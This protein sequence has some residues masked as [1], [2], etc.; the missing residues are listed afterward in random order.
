[1]HRFALVLSLCL[2]AC[3]SPEPGTTGFGLTLSTTTAASTGPQSGTTAGTDDPTGGLTSSGGT[4]TS[5]SGSTDAP[6][7]EGSSGG[8][9][10]SG[11]GS[12]DAGSSGGG[13]SGG[14]PPACGDAVV[15]PGEACDDGNVMGGDGCSPT[16]TV[17]ACGNGVVDQGEACDDGNMVST[18]ACLGTCALA[19]CGD[20]FIQTGVEECEG[21]AIV[22]G[23][24]ANCLVTCNAGFDDCNNMIGDGCEVSVSGDKNNCG[25][26]GKVCAGNE[27]CSAGVCKVQMGNEFGPEHSFVGFVSNHYI[28][29]GCCSVGCADNDAVQA[30]YFCQHFYGNN[31]TPKP[32]YFKAQ[33]PNPTYPKMHKNGGC[34]SNGSDIPNT[35]CDNGPCKVGNWNETTTGLTNLVCVC[36]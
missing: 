30:A 12:T 19:K 13:S 27:I 3:S 34:T 22:N 32:G 11:G 5:T 31:C 4:G 18:D 24:C 21:G 6:A 35:T 29:Q 16:C 14:P 33:T 9:G 20:G 8:V 17:E 25:M 36:N 15:D 2:A 23:A 1:M 28:T 10:S 26:C 7:T